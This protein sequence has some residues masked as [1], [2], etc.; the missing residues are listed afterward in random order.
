MYVVERATKK[1]ELA[2]G[3]EHPSW[4]A[5]NVLRVEWFHP[6]SSDH[7]PATQA[8]LLHDGR[9]LYVMFHVRDRYVRAIRTEYQSMVCRDSCVEFFVQPKGDCGYFNFEVNCGGTVLVYYVE[10]PARVGNGLAKHTVLPREFREAMQVRS[11]MPAP[12]EPEIEGPVQW[13]LA[14]SIP[15]RSFEPYVGSLGEASGQRWRGNFYKCGDETSHPHWASWQPL[16][17][18]LNF[19]QPRFFAPIVFA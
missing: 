6:K 10:D 16:G 4:A 12:V 1:P 18:E 15:L 14:Y 7:R 2:G 17:E 9:Q 8:K 3:W 13:W 5:A 11:S 19:H